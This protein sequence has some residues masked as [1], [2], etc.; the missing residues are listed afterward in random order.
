MHGGDDLRHSD[1][2]AVHRTGSL[3]A[4][5]VASSDPGRLQLFAEITSEFPRAPVS[6]ASL[7]G[8][9]SRVLVDQCLLG[10]VEVDV[11]AVDSGDLIG[12]DVE[13]TAQESLAVDLDEAFPQ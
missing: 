10:N 13:V 2:G 12:R 3:A 4:H 5:P 7:I 8:S 9:G 6:L 1:G 11:F